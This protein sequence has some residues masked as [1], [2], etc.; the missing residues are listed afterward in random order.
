[1]VTTDPLRSNEN[2]TNTQT[3]NEPIEFI[4]SICSRAF[5]TKTGLGVH[6]RRAHP[7]QHDEQ[8][9]RVEI[10]SRWSE[11]EMMIMAQREASLSKEGIRFMN[12][13]LAKIFTNRSVE[14]IKNNWQKAAYKEAVLRFIEQGK[15]VPDIVS[16]SPPTQREAPSVI[17]ID[18]INQINI[19]HLSSFYTNDL[20]PLIQNLNNISKEDTLASRTN[21]LKNI[22]VLGRT[23]SVPTRRRR[24][25][26][27]V[28]EKT[29]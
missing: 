17:F 28:R 26:E 3:N 6:T 29:T 20:Y 27:L 22:F 23:P 2:S 11:E 24:Q 1:M 10:K 8:H 4:C 12:Q 13:E 16:S 19:S 5:S 18:H 25:A 9:E 7:V 15:N 21:Y 14:S